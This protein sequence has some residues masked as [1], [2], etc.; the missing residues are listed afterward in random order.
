M[1]GAKTRTTPHE[2]T[3]EKCRAVGTPRSVGQ[4]DTGCARPRASRG[5]LLVVRQQRGA[6]KGPE[7][8]LSPR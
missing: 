7:S 6:V 3:G 2:N 5:R 8:D 4:F 1:A